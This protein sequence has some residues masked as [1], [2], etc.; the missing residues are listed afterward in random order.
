MG[1]F[2]KLGS[3][4]TFRRSPRSGS[5]TIPTTTP[6]V[7]PTATANLAPPKQK[8]LAELEQEMAVEYAKTRP[9]KLASPSRKKNPFKKLFW[10]GVLVGI[11]AGA[12]WFINLPYPPIRRPIARNA[13]ILLVPSYASMDS[14]Y[15]QAISLTEQASQLI[16]NATAFEDIDLGAEK[17][18]QAQSNL[19][20]LPLWIWDELPGRRYWWYDWRLSHAGFYS[21]RSEVGRLESKVFQERNAQA[22][23][24]EAEQALDRAKQQYQQANQA[25]DKQAAITE[26]RGALSQFEQISGQTLAGRIAQ[27]RSNPYQ[28]EFQR[29]AGLAASN[30]RIATLIEAARQFAWQAA[31]AGQNPPHSV[32]K[33][34][35]IEGLWQEAI[36]RLEQIP[37]DDLTGYAE[38]QRLLATY[39]ANQSQIRIRLQAEQEA[40]RSFQEAQRKIQALLAS[41]PNNPDRVNRNATISQLQGII[42]Q[43]ERV[44]NGTTVYLESQAL[45]LSAKNKLNQL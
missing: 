21:A 39:R 13:P 20:R 7:T 27:Q 6:K 15:R 30:E 14:S 22:A 40:V 33:W 42:H 44:P 17:V 25:A 8:T 23:L 26:W 45:L 10:L 38:A 3:I 29:T 12:I 16:D 11:P 19:D 35:Q 32:E 43:L 9:I 18:E 1:L 36:R 4:A 24:F 2:S 34:R 28:Q 5:T 31:Q 37:A 41:I